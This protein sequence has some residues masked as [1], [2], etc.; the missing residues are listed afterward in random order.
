MKANVPIVTDNYYHDNPASEYAYF[1]LAVLS[2]VNYTILDYGTF[3]EWG[4]YFSESKVYRA[5]L[6]G[7]P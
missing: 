1:D 3:G 4:A 2:S 5:R 7:G 6:I